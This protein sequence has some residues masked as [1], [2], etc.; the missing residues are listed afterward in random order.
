MVANRNWIPWLVLA[1]ILSV[2]GG[3]GGTS[4][5]VQNPP[6]P[7]PSNLS[8]GF[9]PTPPGSI[10]INTTASV[11]AVVS[12]DSSNA[13]VDWSFSCP[14]TSSCGSLSAVHTES[15][16]AVTYTP[17]STLSTN[18]QT[19][20]IV[21]FATADHTRNVVTP[22][23]VTAFASAL[24]GTYVL[25][26]TGSDA[27]GPYQFAGVAI[28]DG[29]GG[30]TSGEQT[31]SDSALAVSDPISGGSYFIGP[32]GRGSLT[33]NT[34]DQNI[35]QQGIE[36]FSLVYIS[37]S[38]A[39]IAKTDDPNNPVS[40]TE[41]AAGTMDLQTSVA[42]PSA[43][44]AFAV[45]GTDANLYPTAFGG[46]LNIDSPGVISGA[47]SV[48][49]QDLG[50]SLTLGTTI[51]GTVSAPD[52][53]GSVKFNLTAGFSSGPIQLTGYIVD[54]TH[55]KLVESDIDSGVGFSTAG[56]AIGQGS[57]T[58]TFAAESSFSGKY[59]FAILG[60]DLS[61]LPTSLASVGRFTANG[62]GGL[63]GGFN[64]EFL[65][66]FG[67]QISDSFNGTYT[68][69][70]SG[71]IDTGSSI[72]FTNNGP[73]PE[74]ILY[75]TGNG[76][77]PLVLD[78]DNNIG[79]LG[80]GVAYPQAAPPFVF[81][82][83]YGLNFAQNTFGSEIDGTGQIT[84]DA[85]AQTLSGMVDTD[86]FFSPIPNTVLTGSFNTIPNTGRFKGKL[87]NPQF[88]APSL[89]MAFYLVDSSHGFFVETDSLNTGTLSFGYLAARTPVCPGCP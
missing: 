55:I 85:S 51:S 49:D 63:T 46:V 23:N 48:A 5:N 17:P 47:G 70:P 42:A 77:V 66:G 30:V 14:N 72:N 59:V 12:D 24:K 75:L 84:V 6:P 16:Q 4:T 21:A 73:G 38:H 1:A 40:S 18:S 57:A 15:G 29:N 54:D 7:P 76:N 80:A 19:V 64:D 56:I 50:G 28:L 20:N 89:G 33:L 27:T 39:L 68:V 65:A 31:F 22:I 83:Q 53:L 37:S 61:G 25:Q 26:A 9:Q 74:F 11:T 35:G 44:Y 62:K 86:Y 34:S 52:S 60:Q 45:S 67:L 58:G 8:I 82:G 32:D 10:A 88:P 41:S 43:G 13:G 81:G 3:C 78:F 2:L 79:S 71:R 36:T 87:S 69:D